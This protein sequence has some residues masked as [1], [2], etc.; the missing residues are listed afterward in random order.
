MPA[1]PP[2]KVRWRATKALE[3]EEAEVM[4]KAP[5]YLWE[6]VKKLSKVCTLTA[7]EH[8]HRIWVSAQT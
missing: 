4:G 1:R 6:V 2:E 8:S 7:T 3:V 5:L